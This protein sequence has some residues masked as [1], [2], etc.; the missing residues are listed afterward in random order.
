MVPT[1]TLLTLRNSDES[2]PNEYTSVGRRIAGP[3]QNLR[4]VPFAYEPLWFTEFEIFGR[5]RSN[6]TPGPLQRPTFLESYFAG[7][8]RLTADDQDEGQRA[9]PDDAA[10]IPC[11]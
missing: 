4:P 2:G 7:T 9:F 3:T 8:G 6:R 5:L 11:S 10:A 1:F